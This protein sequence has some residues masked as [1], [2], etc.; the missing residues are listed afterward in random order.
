MKMVVVQVTRYQAVFFRSQVMVQAVTRWE[1]QPR[2][3][4]A[5]GGLAIQG[6]AIFGEGNWRD[7]KSNGA[8]RAVQLSDAS[9]S[10]RCQVEAIVV[11]KIYA[12]GS[13][14]F[15]IANLPQDTQK[16]WIYAVDVANGSVRWKTPVDG[17][18]Y[19]LFL[20]KTEG[21]VLFSS[22]GLF[23]FDIHNVASLID[24]QTGAV[25]KSPLALGEGSPTA[26]IWNNQV[27]IVRFGYPWI[28]ILNPTT[29]TT[30][31]IYTEQHPIWRGSFLGDRCY[32]ATG[33]DPSTPFIA[34]VNLATCTREWTQ[35][36]GEFVS[37]IRAQGK[38]VVVAGAYGSAASIS[39]LDSASGAAKWTV[40][41]GNAVPLLGPV[42]A[43]QLV[44]QI[45][46]APAPPW[47]AIT[48]GLD[49]DTGAENFRFELPRDIGWISDAGQNVVLS[50][51][52][53]YL[54][55]F[56]IT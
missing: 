50:S 47:T 53:D 46:I 19:A 32:I 3:T 16:S 20:V 49:L 10:W 28:D 40:P 13:T 44:A 36:Y 2:N 27:A 54:F 21:L 22:K 1:I 11:Q 24:K 38:N 30:A 52:L 23:P 56:D 45:R 48:I 55:A 35:P 41:A 26:A 9:D 43:N 5:G 25:K 14:V 8:C 7:P 17:W 6:L 15:F 51:H 33:A 4:S 31:R 37:A 12:E 18:A 42:V 34:A 29:W 39:L